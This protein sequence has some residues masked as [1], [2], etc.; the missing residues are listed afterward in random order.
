MRLSGDEKRA[1]RYDWDH[2][3]GCF[4]NIRFVAADGD[5]AAHLISLGHR[6]I[7]MQTYQKYQ[8][9]CRERAKKT[10]IALAHGYRPEFV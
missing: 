4:Y 6:S 9:A 5:R 7:R 1:I 3:E 2:A 10:A 8:R